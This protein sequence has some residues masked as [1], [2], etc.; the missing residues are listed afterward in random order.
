MKL[1]KQTSD[2][3]KGANLFSKPGVY[4]SIKNFLLV[5]IQEPLTRPF[6]NTPYFIHSDNFSIV[7]E[8]LKFG[9]FQILTKK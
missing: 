2:P 7:G 6:Q 9:N 8:C 1:C 3:N 4:K 5:T